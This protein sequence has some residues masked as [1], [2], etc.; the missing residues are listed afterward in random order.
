MSMSINAVDQSLD[1][2]EFEVDQTNELVLTITYTRNRQSIPNN[3]LVECQ[4]E[5]GGP[6]N[7]TVITN[8]NI[9]LGSESNGVFSGVFP[10]V[11]VEKG[12]TYDMRVKV[13]INAILKVNKTFPVTTI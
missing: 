11:V 6:S 2:L 5:D 1:D 10:I 4:L 7:I 3:S 12:R 9:T 13:T 8:S